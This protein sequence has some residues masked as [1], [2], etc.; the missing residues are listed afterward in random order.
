MILDELENVS[1][2]GNEEELNKIRIE[3]EA[4]FLRAV[5]YFSLVNLYA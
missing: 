5:Y 4:R 3:G 2:K 1:A